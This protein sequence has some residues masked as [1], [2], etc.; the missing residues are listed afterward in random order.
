MPHTS[1]ACALFLH[2]PTSD[3]VDAACAYA[4]GRMPH[5]SYACAL[6]LQ[7]L[8]R[9]TP[10][11]LRMLLQQHMPT[12]HASYAYGRMPHTSPPHAAAGSI[13]LRLIRI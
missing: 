11:F 12:S 6:F 3:T 2:A 9:A 5:T 4:Y 7:V 8:A 13:R 1:Y 10:G